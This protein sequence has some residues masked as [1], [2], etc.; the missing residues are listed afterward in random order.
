[1]ASPD[2]HEMQ[3]P[4]AA[5]R[6]PARLD[7]R[8]R[9]LL[10]GPFSGP[11]HDPDLTRGET[12][13]Q[14]FAETVRL[15]ADRPAVEEDG[16]RYSYTDLDERAQRIARLLRSRGLGRGSLVGHWFPRG[17]T[18]YAVLLGI[19]KAGTA[20]VPLDPDLP[21]ARVRQLAA[22]CGMALL[23]APG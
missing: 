17:L 14:L 18:A 4:G 13:A 22:E 23:L 20:Y 1:M 2:P 16:H 5:L 7:P 6:D 21:P 12:L 15:H 11:A 10:L 3:P 19:L 9:V 8:E